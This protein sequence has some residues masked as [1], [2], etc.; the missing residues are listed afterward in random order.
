MNERIKQL[1]DEAEIY[2]DRFHA[3]DAKELYWIKYKEKFAQ[4]IVQ[5]C[6]TICQYDA[7]DDDDQFDLGRVHQAKEITHLIKKHLG[8]EE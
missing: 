8:V 1:A 4:L 2:V 5:E 6:I 7:D 3:D